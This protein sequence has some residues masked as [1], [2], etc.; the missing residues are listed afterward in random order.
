MG[1]VVNPQDDAERAG[2][3]LCGELR[4]QAAD[5]GARLNWSTIITV[6]SPQ[7]V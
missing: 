4:H 2:A 1:A 6:T 7:V 3:A 5:D